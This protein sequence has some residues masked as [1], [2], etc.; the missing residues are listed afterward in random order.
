MKVRYTVPSSDAR[1]AYVGNDVTVNFSVPFNFFVGS[2]LNVSLVNDTTGAE[3]VQTLTTNY[4]VAG[5]GGSTGTVTMLVAP[6]AGFTLVIERDIP[7]TQEI[8]LESNDPFPAE[9]TEE[10]F[11]R[12]TMLSQQ[13]LLRAKQSPKL[14]ASYDPSGA[15]ITLPLPVNGQILAGKSDASGWEHVAVGTLATSA[16]PL[17]LSTTAVGQVLQTDGTNYKNVRMRFSAE[18]FGIVGDN[19]TPNQ[20]AI[21]NAIATIAALTPYGGGELYFPPGYYQHSGP[22][23]ITTNGVCLTGSSPVNTRLITTSATADQ[24]VIGTTSL[25]PSG[26]F[27]RGLGFGSTVPRTAGASVRFRYGSLGGAYDT[28]YYNP[29][30]GLEFNAAYQCNVVRARIETPTAT[31]GQGMYFE[32]N[33]DALGGGIRGSDVYCSYVEMAGPS[34]GTQPQCGVFFKDFSGVWFDKVGTAQMG[35]GVLF[36]PASATSDIVEHLFS[37]ACSWDSGS[38]HGALLQPNGGTVRRWNSVGDWFSSNAGA[39]FNIPGA[40]AG[41][42]ADI[43]LTSPQML[44]NTLQGFTAV[45]GS[46]TTMSNVRMV[47][48]EITGNSSASS[49]TY[50][51]VLWTDVD[52]FSILGGRIGQANGFTD[53]HKYNV[54][55]SG[56]NTFYSI[57]ACDIAGGV[58]GP[59]TGHVKSSSQIVRDCIGYVNRNEGLATSLTTD[60]SGD[61]TITHGVTG[62]PTIVFAQPQAASAAW[63]VIPHTIGATTFKVRVFTLAGA[64]ASAAM[65]NIAWDARL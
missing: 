56:T 48:P 43:T 63:Y 42:V 45:K 62:T 22:I 16:I 11:D 36:A 1:V 37:R 57:I 23:V 2:D 47:S 39:G 58:T 3:T 50:S 53:R 13:V 25:A 24:V 30:R 5:G 38:G 52:R 64:S 10:G 15:A 65:D 20:T 26:N 51:G 12:N 6:A 54:E 33:R 21:D 9:V 27:I 28:V 7:F 4:T 46:L 14:P 29:F 41:V 34:S 59:I 8:D 18:L 44:G 31:T 55:M 40:L 61:V 19:S 60:G 32:G 35:T 49:G 17:L